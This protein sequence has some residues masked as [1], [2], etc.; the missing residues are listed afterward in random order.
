MKSENPELSREQVC[1]GAIGAVG[2]L[3]VHLVIGSLYQWGIINIYIT[4]Y[5]RTKEP[6]VNL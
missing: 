6:A 5:F 3:F 4:A 1:W 2:G